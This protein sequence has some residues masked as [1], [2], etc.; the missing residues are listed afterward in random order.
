M[1]CMYIMGSSVLLGGPNFDSG[2]ARP[3]RSSMI[4]GTRVST[5]GRE[6]RV[7]GAA[8]ERPRSAGDPLLCRRGALGDR[9]EDGVGDLVAGES[10]RGVGEGE[11]LHGPGLA[12]C[13]SHGAGVVGVGRRGYRPVRHPVWAEVRVFCLALIP[14]IP[15]GPIS[16]YLFAHRFAAGQDTW[17]NAAAAAIDHPSWTTSLPMR[18]RC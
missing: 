1:C 8:E 16:A 15:A 7:S 9:D 14:R 4:H 5:N 2:L 10:E 12:R 6:N 17:K 11:A 13:G 18:S 3:C